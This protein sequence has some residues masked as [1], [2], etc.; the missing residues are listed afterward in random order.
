MTHRLMSRRSLLAGLAAVGCGVGLSSSLLLRSAHSS[1]A[2]KVAMLIPGRIDDGGFMEAGYRGLLLIEQ[3][4]NAA[5]RYIHE[6]APEQE[7]MMNA[8]RLLAADSPDLIIAHGGQTAEATLAAAAELLGTQFVVVQGNVTGPNVS[9][10]EVLQEQS[11]WLAGAAAGRLT[12]TQVVGHISG[13]RVPPGLKGRAAFASGLRY[14]NPEA[15]LLTNFCGSQDDADRARQVAL[16]EIE[17]GAD[18]IFTML[19]AGRMGAIAACRERGIWQIGNVRDWTIVEPDVFIASAIANVSIPG[20]L[21]AKEV[22]AAT[23]TPGIIRQIGLEVPEAV[24]LALSSSVDA[25]IAA[26]IAVLSA[27]LVAGEI[28]V[29][30]EYDGPEFEA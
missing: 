4:L 27:Q 3:E 1:T 21:A 13:I 12:Q 9:S 8:L 6:V 24:S 14:T 5:V 10:Y 25:A 17:A 2:L 11:A 16:A 19:N 28:E 23:F 30:T 18:L 29:I 7:A 26:E 22:A 15:Q 20:F